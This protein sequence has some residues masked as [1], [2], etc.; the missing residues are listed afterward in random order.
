MFNSFD[1]DDLTVVVIGAHGGLGR[2]F[3]SQIKSCARVKHV[4]AFSRDT[5]DFSDE[6]TIAL[7]AKQ[8]TK[9]GAIDVVI[10]ATGLLHA[11]SW[12]GEYESIRTVSVKCFTGQSFFS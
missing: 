6:K 7:A 10:V 5:L 8:S 9:F 2:S 11:S 3:V 12:D 4:H 1:R